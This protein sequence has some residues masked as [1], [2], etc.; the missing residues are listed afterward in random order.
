M[1]DLI[2]INGLPGSGK[3]ADVVPAVPGSALGMAAS[4]MMWNLAAAMSGTVIL[5]TWWF[6]PRDLPF[7]EAGLR[8]CDP[9]SV[10]EAWCDVPP[11]VAKSRYGARH[12]HRIHDD[13]GKLADAWPRWE[14]EAE[15]LGVGPVVRVD[16]STPVN[17]ADVSKQIANARR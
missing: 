10:I 2:L 1:V 12:R 7:V 16:T 6:R 5:E 15:P 3:M 8:R 4:D 17:L 11:H 9:T 14:T 13:Q